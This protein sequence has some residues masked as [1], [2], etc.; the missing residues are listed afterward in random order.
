[1]TSSTSSI[2]DLLDL[3]FGPAAANQSSAGAIQV[4]NRP[5]VSNTSNSLLLDFGA[6]TTESS[7]DDSEQKEFSKDGD[8]CLFKMDDVADQGSNTLTTGKSAITPTSPWQPLDVIPGQID[9][10][11]SRQSKSSVGSLSDEDALLFDP[12]APTSPL[13]PTQE[14]S[15]SEPT[16]KKWTVTSG[17][18]SD[19]VQ[20]AGRPNLLDFANETWPSEREENMA[21]PKRGKLN[22]TMERSFEDLLAGLEEDDL[23]A[24]IDDILTTGSLSPQ[25]TDASFNAMAAQS[26]KT[27]TQFEERVGRVKDKE[28]GSKEA[29]PLQISDD[30]KTI[31]EI[32]GEVEETRTEVADLLTSDEEEPQQE[33]EIVEDEPE[34]NVEV[35]V[36][37]HDE[38]DTQTHDQDEKE[39]V[40]SDMDDSTT[41]NSKLKREASLDFNDVGDTSHLDV[42]IGKQKTSLRKKGSLAR[43]RKPTRTNVRNILSS[44]E[45]SHF[46][47]TTETKQ[48]PSS[49]VNGFGAEEEVFTGDK[50]GSPDPTSPPAKKSSH[51]MM[52]LP[53]LGQPMLPRKTPQPRASPDEE[54]VPV[55]PKRDPK[56]MGIKLPMPQLKPTKR[57]DRQEET[58]VSP[59]F[60]K[61]ALRKVTSPQE[62]EKA[63]EKNDVF[64]IPALKAVAPDKPARHTEKAETEKLF[65]KP[66][67]KTVPKMEVDTAPDP[68]A[69]ETPYNI[70]LRRVD[71][72]REKSPVKT[73]QEIENIFDT[74]SLKKVQREEESSRSKISPENEGRFDVPAL[75]TV[76]SELKRSES[77]EI[78]SEKTFNKPPLRNTPKVN[79]DPPASPEGKGKFDLPSLKR[80]PRVPRSN[81]SELSSGGAFEVP[82]LRNRPN[83]PVGTQLDFDDATKESTENK[84]TF[85]VPQLKNTPKSS[86]PE[87]EGSKPAASKEEEPSWLKDMK[88]RKT[89]TKSEESLD[90]LK[91]T[92]TP[93]WM[94]TAAEKREKA[95]E[96]LNTKENQSKTPG[97]GKPQWTDMPRLRKTPNGLPLQESTESSEN[98][99]NGNPNQET[100]RTRLTSTGSK[101]GD[102]SS[103]SSSRERTPVSGGTKDQYVPSW[104]KTSDNR[105]QSTPNL[106]II[107]PPSADSTSI[108]QWKRDLAERRKLRKENS[109]DT[110]LKAKNDSTDAG[111]ASWKTEFAMKKKLTPLPKTTAEIRTSSSEPEWKKRADEKR[112]RLINSGLL[113]KVK[114]PDVS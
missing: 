80:T 53:G 24:D 81:S 71:S 5:G 33:E 58:S 8:F 54:M 36:T 89:S 32:F 26:K 88:L 77:Q 6:P 78:E 84:H 90:Q 51:L 101:D 27:Y 34:P 67:L 94:K 38:P 100:R 63:V 19:T 99:I 16:L 23:D 17:S 113:D 43:R 110:P 105:H 18:D 40:L 49:E 74:P 59:E 61:P 91:E 10:T 106:N 103:S 12:L 45:D 29:E 60:E 95:A 109:V 65:T 1:M 56:A 82:N 92:E 73:A 28:E 72:K 4:V 93:L 69:T 42:N 47:D 62:T 21:D 97:D 14:T 102:S 31:D 48:S 52:P 7:T 83:C 35:M 15:E 55:E 25:I 104:L 108:P 39:A 98:T 37:D 70:P 50:S 64:E 96:I 75:K 2:D 86:K 30:Q 20:P 9:L 85:D 22:R 114:K 13:K 46:Q 79:V 68:V 41:E 107:T 11:P 44:S 87:I 3:D 66:Q 57:S 112:Q 76:S 111:A